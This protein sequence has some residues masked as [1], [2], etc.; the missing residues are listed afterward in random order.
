MRTRLHAPLCAVILCVVT[1]AAGCAQHY[2]ASSVNDVSYH[3]SLDRSPVPGASVEA[4]GIR[5]V[6]DQL[7]GLGGTLWVDGICFG[8]VLAGDHVEVTDD[9]VVLVNGEERERVGG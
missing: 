5:I 7:K 1:L 8:E 9:A 4:M 6:M 2:I 3:M